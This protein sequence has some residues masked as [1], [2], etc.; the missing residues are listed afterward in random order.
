MFRRHP[1]SKKPDPVAPRVKKELILFAGLHKT[2]TTSIQKTCGANHTD[3]TRAGVAYPLRTAN[4]QPQD[5]HTF[6][7]GWMFKDAPHRV[8]LARQ[9]TAGNDARVADRQ[10]RLRDSMGNDIKDQRRV[11]L[12][13][14]GVSVFS[15]SELESM[16]RWLHEQGFTVRVICHIRHL[17]RWIASMVAQRV[18][19]QMGLT[20]EQAV[21]E[22]V[23][24][25]GI[26]RPRIDAIRQV[27]PDTEFHSHELAVSHEFGPAGFLLEAIGV[28]VNSEMS[29]IRAN[30]GR[31]AIAVRALSILH[32]RFGRDQWRE[33]PA[34]FRAHLEQAG[35]KGLR[36]L[37]GKKFELSEHEV[38]PLLPMLQEENAW[39]RDTFGEE[40]HDGHLEFEGGGLDW[41]PESVTL[42]QEKLQ[43]C[44]PEV[45]EWVMGN[46]GRLGIA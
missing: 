5:N 1:S 21:Q 32:E 38:A 43:L 29:W 9:F 34:E 17:S 36:R 10:A 35:V 13:A 22:F 39:L 2:G 30:E 25:G 4:G 19:G 26:I 14:E 44:R 46:L 23:A 24:A 40:F 18:A 7:L 15:V 28:P 42:F 31:S 27:F 45:R 16:R 3:L 37:P 6:Q 11:L 8:G 41:T 33:T 12:V 20:I